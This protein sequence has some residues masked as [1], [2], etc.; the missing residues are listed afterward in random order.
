MDVET[1]EP[2]ILLHTFDRDPGDSQ[3]FIWTKSQEDSEALIFH[4]NHADLGAYFAA[5]SPLL[6]EFRLELSGAV[7]GD[8]VAALRAT[9]TPTCYPSL[10]GC[11][12]DLTP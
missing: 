2:G 1:G 12:Q 5:M 8:A 3:G 9:R 6:D 11:V 7:Y 10:L 4:L